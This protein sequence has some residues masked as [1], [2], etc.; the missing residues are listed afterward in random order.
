MLEETK[1]K[2][3]ARCDSG[4][5]CSDECK[6]QHVQTDEHQLLCV[7][8][9]QLEE[10]QMNQRLA[11]LPLK[12][13]SQVS[14]KRR[15]IGL[16]G[17][18]PMV[19]CQIGGKSSEALWDT[20]AQVSMVDKIWLGKNH[21]T[22]EVDSLEEFLEGDNL[23]LFTANN[24]RVSVEGVVTLDV[25]MGGFSVPVP[26][27]VSE[28]RVTQPI[29]GYNV[30]KHL[31]FEGGE[32]SGELLRMSCPGILDKNIEA[33][34]NLIRNEV[35]REDVVTTAKDVVIPANCRFKVKCRT[36]YRASEPEESVLFSPSVLDHEMGLSESEVEL[37]RG[38]V[39]VGDH[40]LEVSE[41]VTKAKLGRG[42]IHVVVSNPTNNPILLEKGVTLGSIEAV[43]A[44]IPLMPKD[45]VVEPTL[46][47]AVEAVDEL[48]PW[49]P[50]V[51]LSHL[52][53]DKKKIV[54]QVL[55]EEADVFCQ[56]GVLQGDVPDMEMEINLTDQVPIVI[57]H[58]Q[59]PRSFY[60]EV[61]NFVNDMIVNN[62]VRE[63]RSS[64]SSPIVCAR[65]PCGGLRMCIDYRALNKKM[66]PDK[67]PIPRISEIFD[68]LAGQEWFSTLD[69]AK[70]YHQGYVK[71]E[72]RK[73][74]AFST[75]WGLYEWIR[76]PMGISNAP[77][78]FQRYV[79][80]AL[81]GLLDRICAAY[82]DDILIYGTTFE[83]H[84]R[85]FRTV[86]Q[87]LRVKGIR[88]RA[89]KCH[90][91]KH[92]LRYLGRLISKD[93]HR[94]DPKDTAAV[95][96]FRE[97][98]KNIGELRT[99]MGFLGYYRSYVPNFSKRFKSHYD[100]L[101]GISS[102]GKSKRSVAEMEV[103]WTEDRQKV[104]DEVLEYLK[105]PEVLAF[106]DFS[107]PFVITC[108]ASEKGLGAVLYQKQVGKNRVISYASRTL[109]DAESKYHL[110]SGKLEFLGL[111]WAVCEKFGD[112]LCT[113]EHFTVYTDNN[114]LTYVMSTAKLNATGYRWV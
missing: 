20:G 34:V 112:Y 18:K 59:I 76:I 16:V 105:S 49:L 50:P 83:D 53:E 10:V 58:R 36:G 72:H 55:R 82:L 41:S 99:L 15:L 93:G 97:P 47:N 65:K 104:V 54:E 89:D 45:H 73:Y 8:I 64:Y 4:C 66:I 94:P 24:S 17:E 85:N 98:P 110:H 70:A 108:D 91:F 106:P 31:I 95:D 84:V 81:R 79:N 111:K 77:P 87:R 12:E 44:V 43:S 80:N 48:G 88:L 96:K 67:M 92:E 3:C 68:G 14:V 19:K 78:V 7:S 113:G 103:E 9:Q 42:Y 23:H 1:V 26:F 57:P 37:K 13:K 62:W 101:K 56:E 39:P 60:E 27:V 107:L 52:P 61:K 28:S 102:K 109:N 21:P 29:I 86:L 6:Q 5:Y 74:T 25:K 32:E 69:M 33:V 38:Y 35:P 22:A 63:S 40:V 11:A 46:I 2:R 51:D 100:L 90:I 75:P 30:I 114:P 71:E